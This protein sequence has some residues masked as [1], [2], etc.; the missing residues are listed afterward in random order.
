MARAPVLSTRV[1]IGIAV[2]IVGAYAV[3]SGAISPATSAPAES[4][5]PMPTSPPPPTVEQASA[6][7]A[8]APTPTP[9][10][11]TPEAAPK[12]MT[13]AS[14]RVT[15]SPPPAWGCGASNITSENMVDIVCDGAGRMRIQV[16]KAG[17]DKTIDQFEKSTLIGNE[18]LVRK[19]ERQDYGGNK[20]LVWSEREAAYGDTLHA[21]FYKNGNE[22]SFHR[23]G[24]VI[25]G[26]VSIRIAVESISFK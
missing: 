4:S 13:F 16:T 12:P 6:P 24:S 17:E 26:A 1:G 5:E 8:L 7:P 22:V 25:E 10:K 2:L 23:S 21:V 3:L 19:R 18:D 14:H 15:I 20:V 9:P 11:V